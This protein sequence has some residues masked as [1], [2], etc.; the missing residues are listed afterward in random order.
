MFC[1]N[2]GKQ[3][4]EGAVFC[5]ECGATVAPGG[6]AAG[7]ADNNKKNKKVWLLPAVGAAIVAV[8]LV[9][10][11]WSSISNSIAGT[12]MSPENYL[13]KV[14]RSNFVDPTA[15]SVAEAISSMRDYATD[16]T[17]AEVTMNIKLDKG[18]WDLLDDADVYYDS[19]EIDW[20]NSATIDY[21]MNAKEDKISLVADVAVNKTDLVS[22][23]AVGFPESGETYVTFPGLMDQYIMTE[24]EG[25]Y[26]YNQ[27]I[28]VY[29]AMPKKSDAK[30][31]IKNY[32]TAVVDSVE[33]V[34]KS[35]TTIEADGISQKVTEL[36]FKVDGELLK[37][38][39]TSV[40][41]ELKDD[42]KL[43]KIVTNIAKAADADTDDVDEAWETIEE[44]LDEI[45][46]V[47]WDEVDNLGKMKIYVNGKGDIVGCDLRLDDGYSEYAFTSLTA[48]KGNKFG[49][50]VEFSADGF[51]IAIEG[52]GKISGN[53]RSGKFV[54]N[55]ESYGINADVLEIETK[56]VNTKLLEDGIFNGSVKIKVPEG[57][58]KLAERE[59][60]GAD[61]SFL[62]DLSISVSSTSKSTDK[63][64]G[65]VQLDYNDKTCAKI[66]LSAKTGKSGKIEIPSK[67][68]ESDD[69]DEIEALVEDIKF[70]SLLS[71]MRKAKFPG[72]AIEAVE[73]IVEYYG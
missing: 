69:Y 39:S 34:E 62:S 57:L 37:N 26:D 72:E 58:V 46:D 12:V 19:D 28:D 48:E 1:E 18:L 36:S 52:N 55:V 63:F 70:D 51:E 61:L 23:K 29:G 59:M 27:F 15:D 7:G 71:K 45:D 16:G 65:S 54:L 67:Y 11:N 31:L 40:L 56:K 33:D 21:T 8:L 24:G 53:K 14:V 2:C 17:K 47:D 38:V 22:M 42:A 43:K 3:I 66:D 41:T 50:L 44:A 20:L 49:S 68:V 6:Q 30:K 25:V 73:E 5:T 32:L 9:L 4:E 10:F 64:K 13:A 60:Y 35:K